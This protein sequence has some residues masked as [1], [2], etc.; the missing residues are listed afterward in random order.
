MNDA[1]LADLARRVRNVLASEPGQSPEPPAETETIEEPTGKPLDADGDEVEVGKLY[2]LTFGTGATP[3][4][5]RVEAVK[6]GFAMV[7]ISLEPQ[8]GVC[9]VESSRL[10]VHHPGDGPPSRTAPQGVLKWEQSR[11]GLFT[12]ESASSDARYGVSCHGEEWIACSGGMGICHGTVY[13]CL[14]ACE[15]LAAKPDKS[16]LSTTG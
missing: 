9:D 15:R 13:E 16:P 14:A 2:W 3:G 10:R 11:L 5:R 12:A 4:W 1:D 8:G 6:L 7:R